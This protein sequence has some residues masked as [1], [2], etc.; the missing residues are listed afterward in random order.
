MVTADGKLRHASA[1][2]NQDLF[3]GVR[4][5]GGNFGVVTS[6]DYQL[7]SLPSKILAGSRLFPFSQAAN[8]LTALAEFAEHMPDEM[9]V[10]VFVVRDPK[11]PPPGT[12][13]GYEAVYNGAPHEGERLLEP[14]QKLGKPL[15]DDVAL[16][17]Y[18]AAQGG[19]GKARAAPSDRVIYYKSG[20]VG[21]LSG[22]LID[23]V[24]R[25][26]ASSP[27]VVEG[28][29]LF[30]HGGATGRVKPDATAFWN[31]WMKYTLLLIG[32]WD[33]AQN[34]QSVKTAHAF[35]EGLEPFTRNYYINTDVYEGEQRL[36]ATYGDNYSRLVKLK[37]KYDPT[38][39]F[40]LNANIVPTARG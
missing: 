22:K 33:R 32:S 34:D 14:L 29:V 17:T 21:D 11:L 39:L 25:R 30:R 2:E 8:V 38:N 37:D 13:V 15:I 3:W 4:G 40:K 20:F 28:I 10:A 36:R 24:V 18:V 6:F 7:H 35:W 26:F 12:M 1:D 23:E 5:G 9:Y 16:K 19:K 31:R 27:P